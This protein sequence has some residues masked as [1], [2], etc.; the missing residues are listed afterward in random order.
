[1]PG[2]V[3][4]RLVT[5]AGPVLVLG[6]GGP[7]TRGRSSGWLAGLF[8]RQTKGASTRSAELAEASADVVGADTEERKCQ[9]V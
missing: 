5:P 3:A 7:V 2:S 1:M 8:R 9:S 6:L 4:V